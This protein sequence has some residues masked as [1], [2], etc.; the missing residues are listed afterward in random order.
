MPPDLGTLSEC[1]QR[2]EHEIP[3]PLLQKLGA[4]LRGTGLREDRDIIRD[5]LRALE[6][7]KTDG[8]FFVE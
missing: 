3:L 2:G 8:F 7:T 5:D 4:A 1:V 6:L